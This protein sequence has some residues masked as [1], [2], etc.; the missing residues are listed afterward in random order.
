MLAEGIPASSIEQASMQAGYPVPVLQL[1]DEINLKLMRLVRLSAIEGVEA[2]GG[3][4][5]AH[6][7]EAVVDRML[8]EFERPGRLEGAGFYEYEDGRRVRLWPGLLE[9]FEP[10]HEQAPP[11]R[12]LSERMLFIE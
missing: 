2:A 9:A 5:E 7:S 12:D 8:D 4:W 1:A 6:P 11:L 3:T 10:D